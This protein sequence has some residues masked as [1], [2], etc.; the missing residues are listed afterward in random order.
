MSNIVTTKSDVNLIKRL[1]DGLLD[2]NHLGRVKLLLTVATI[3]VGAL[4][5]LYT[6]WFGSTPNTQKPVKVE[7]SDSPTLTILPDKDATVQ[8]RDNQTGGIQEDTIE[9]ILKRP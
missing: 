8:N 4:C 1:W 9:E 3:T 5:T 2:P 7:S 6:Y